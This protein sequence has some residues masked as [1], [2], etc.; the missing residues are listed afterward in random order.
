MKRMSIYEYDEEATRQA[1]R[2]EEYER[3]LEEG[4]QKGIEALIYD[5]LIMKPPQSIGLIF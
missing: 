1:I 2:V 5:N 3:G 4:M